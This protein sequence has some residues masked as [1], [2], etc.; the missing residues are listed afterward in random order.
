MPA[1]IQAQL[2]PLWVLNRMIF[3]REYHS[4]IY[5]AEAFA[6][7]QLVSEIPYSI[8]CAVLYWVLMVYPVGFGQGAA[9]LNGTGFQLLVLIFV[10]FFGVTLAQL[11]GA[12]SPSIQIAVLCNPLLATI[13]MTFCGVTIPYP[14]IG[15]WARTWLYYL[16][17]FT[18][19]MGA[20]IS[21]E[22]HGLK[23]ECRSNEFSVFEPP[24]GQTCSAWASEF[25]S[26]FG[27]Y[28]DNADDTSACRYCPYSV[29]EDFFVPL[30]IRYE[31]RW[32][33]AF[34]LFGFFFF[35]FILVVLA[36]RFLRFAKR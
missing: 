29:G 30:K 22:L 15:T 14:D 8:L 17:P 24:E 7:A 34:V 3:V 2:T 32:R 27:G 10:E 35:N 13:L 33:D 12:I 23:I 20:M 19:V 25:V 5:S 31:D 11:V 18:R 1:I 16:D 21:T 28:L 6:I 26:A 36:S 4:R 9:G